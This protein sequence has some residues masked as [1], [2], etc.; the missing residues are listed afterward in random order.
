MGKPEISVIIPL[1][2]HENYIERT[3]QSVLEQSFQD[4]EIVIVDDGSTDNSVALVKEIEDSRIRLYCQENHGAPN[5]LNT[6]ITHARGRY[7]A[8][9]NSDDIFAKE[10]L[11]KCYQLIEADPAIDIV[12]TGVQCIDDSDQALH[13]IRSAPLYHNRGKRSHED[14]VVPLDLFAD[15]FLISPSNIFCSISLVNRISPFREL[16]YCHDWDFF[17]RTSFE[18]H[19][20]LLP[21]PLLEY[22]IHSSNT[23]GEDK[24][25]VYFEIAVVIADF[26][27]TH[28]LDGLVPPGQMTLEEEVF[29]SLRYHY[30]DRMLA[31]LL[32]RN[33]TDDEWEAMLTSLLQKGD[34]PLYV[35]GI[36]QIRQ[37]IENDACASQVFSEN[38]EMS[39]KLEKLENQKCCSSFFSKV[40]A[41]V[42]ARLQ[43]IRGGR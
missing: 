37:L 23:L 15:N 19:L 4:F 18:S 14:Q 16:R 38:K 29:K 33:Y 27:R 40:G 8:I 9:L 20:R 6:G 36:K 2:N 35:A 7:V 32:L 10:R 11:E 43:Q 42:K 21:E 24:A 12:C 5:T 39:I 17:L 1:Y 41:I 22:R 13:Q 26:L 28:D 3:I 30:V 31:T 34:N 25:G